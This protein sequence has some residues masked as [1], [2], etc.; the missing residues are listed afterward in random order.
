MSPN[1]NKTTVDFKD[2]LVWCQQATDYSLTLTLHRSLV[3]V[4]SQTNVANMEV[5]ECHLVDKL[6]NISILSLFYLC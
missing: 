5:E 3:F 4:A 2:N 6:R 1:K